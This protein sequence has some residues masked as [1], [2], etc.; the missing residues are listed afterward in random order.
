MPTK[1][2]DVDRCGSKAGIATSRTDMIGALV[3]LAGRSASF[4]SK[5]RSDPPVSAEVSQQVGVAAG[6]GLDF[7]TSDQIS[8]AAHDAGLDQATSALVDDYEQTQLESLKAG[9]LA[10]A[11]LALISLTT[12]ATSSTRKPTGW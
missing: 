2:S 8:A 5:A 7:V 4:T 6:T 1:R 9:L 10:A 11:F 12:P 3:V